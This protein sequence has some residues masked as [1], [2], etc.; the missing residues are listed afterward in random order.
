MT[1]VPITSPLAVLTTRTTQEH[2]MTTHSTTDLKPGDL[3]QHAAFGPGLVGGG[4]QILYLARDGFVYAAVDPDG[5]ERV[6]T[7]TRSERQWLDYRGGVRCTC[8]HNPATTNGPEEDCEIHG[9]PYAEWVKRA[10]GAQA[11]SARIETVRPGHVH[12][13]V[14]DLDLG[15]DTGDSEEDFVAGW[16]SDFP[17]YSKA[18]LRLIYRAIAAQRAE[19]TTPADESTTPADEQPTNATVTLPEGTPEKWLRVVSGDD[20]PWRNS[21]GGRHFWAYLI[22]RG[23]VT[24][25][26]DE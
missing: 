8:D 20:W 2:I 14:D 21:D 4:K 15:P 12:L 1:R 25:G 17:E 11:E 6:E 10:A 22:E 19:S 26:W 5:W 23:A 7:C 13:H 16:Q 3:V 18:D 24:L 9:R